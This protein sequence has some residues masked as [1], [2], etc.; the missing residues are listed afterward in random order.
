MLKLLDD[1]LMTQETKDVLLEDLLQIFWQQ[2]NH[3]DKKLAEVSKRIQE[4]IE[5]SSNDFQG[6]KIGEFDKTETK[7]SYYIIV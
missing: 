2:E 6:K 4:Q 5:R 3:K 7:V 1:L